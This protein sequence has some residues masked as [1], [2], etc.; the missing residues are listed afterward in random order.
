[1]DEYIA[2]LIRRTDQGTLTWHSEALL[3]DTNLNGVRLSFAKVSAYGLRIGHVFVP[4]EEAQIAA[5]ARVV[6]RRTQEQAVEALG[7]ALS[8]AEPP[9][10]GHLSRYTLTVWKTLA[11]YLLALVEGGDAEAIR[12][13]RALAHEVLES[14]E[15]APSEAVQEQLTAWFDPMDFAKFHEMVA[16]AVYGMDSFTSEPWETLTEGER[17]GWMKHTRPL[18]R[19]LVGGFLG[20]EG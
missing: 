4:F 12:D 15:D 11:R 10:G 20:E 19:V 2:E 18:M 3:Y 14:E 6:D 7:A 9:W 16:Q 1:M 13:L 8:T 17:A 5:L